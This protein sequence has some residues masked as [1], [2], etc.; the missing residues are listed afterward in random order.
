MNIFQQIAS[1]LKKLWE[2]IASPKASNAVEQS[3]SLVNIALPIVDELSTIDP[4]TAG[5]KDVADAYRKYGVP[6]IQS[7]TQDSIGNALLNLATQILRSKLPANKARL[8]T[9]ILNTAVQL[10]VTV[11]KANKNQS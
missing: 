1:G 5:L 10:T 3:A 4:R 9:N 8:S 2:I 11:L 6:M 7:Y